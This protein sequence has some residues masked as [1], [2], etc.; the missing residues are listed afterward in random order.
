MG[1][2]MQNS[3]RWYAF[4]RAFD[5]ARIVPRACLVACGYMTWHVTEWFMGLKEPTGS[6]A[7]FTVTVYGVIP[8]ILAFY[9]ANGVKWEPPK[10]TPQG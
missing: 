4:W 1:A 8:A 5:A 7:A 2:N 10:D 3:K 6:Q 9:M